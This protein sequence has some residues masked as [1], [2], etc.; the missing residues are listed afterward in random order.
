MSILTDHRCSDNWHFSAS[1]DL[2]RYFHYLLTIV[3]YC[4]VRYLRVAQTL[5]EGGGMAL[6][7]AISIVMN[8]DY[9][10][11]RRRRGLAAY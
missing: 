8:T 3:S 6:E 2:L 4:F 10:E 5:K 1:L 9:K 7:I 11:M